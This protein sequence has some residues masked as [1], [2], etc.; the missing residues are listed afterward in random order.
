MWYIPLMINNYDN[1][2]FE[3]PFQISRVPLE[4]YGIAY[5]DT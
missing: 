4:E 3:K 5:S 2:K 1:K